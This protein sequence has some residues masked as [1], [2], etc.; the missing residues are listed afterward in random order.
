MRFLYYPA[1]LVWRSVSVSGVLPCLALWLAV[2]RYDHCNQASTPKNNFGNQNGDRDEHRRRCIGSRPRDRNADRYF[3]F[4]IE[5][6]SQGSTRTLQHSNPIIIKMG[7]WIFKNGGGDCEQ[8]NMEH[9]QK[10]CSLESPVRV[11]QAQTQTQAQN[12]TS[13]KTPPENPP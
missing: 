3:F 9:H 5:A 2:L 13:D 8:G 12:A 7:H 4:I 6:A 10:Y 11:P 1:C